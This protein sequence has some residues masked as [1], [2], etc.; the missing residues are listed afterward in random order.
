MTIETLTIY[1]NETFETLINEIFE[2]SL[3]LDQKDVEKL[4]EAINEYTIARAMLQAKQNQD[5][6]EKK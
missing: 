4:D 3:K 2:I 5:K 6:K 1:E